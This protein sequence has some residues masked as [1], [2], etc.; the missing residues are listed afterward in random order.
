MCDHK[1][2]KATVEVNRLEDTG[3]FMAD[4]SVQ[5]EECGMPFGFLGLQPGLNLQGAMVSIDGETARLAIH[6][7]GAR[8][9]PLQR[10]RFGINRFDS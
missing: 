5:C 10:M 1:K 9:S 7:R 6:P 2:F 3:Q 4:V 8:P